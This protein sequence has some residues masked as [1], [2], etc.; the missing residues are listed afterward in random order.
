MSAAIQMLFSLLIALGAVSVAD[1][2]VVTDLSSFDSTQSSYISSI[3][4]DST[5][6]SY[7]KDNFGSLNSQADTIRPYP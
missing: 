5:N 3:V 2:E 7:I 4:N 6:S 1:G